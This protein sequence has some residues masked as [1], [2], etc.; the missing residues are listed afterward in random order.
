M[1]LS[2]CV[3]DFS[4][5]VP[6]AD[7]A[8]TVSG[9]TPTVTF[10]VPETIYLNPSDT[11]E[12]QY[13]VN[14]KS[15][16]TLVAS[17]NDTSGIIYFNCSSATAVTGLTCN[18][19]T[20]SL[21]ATSSTSGSLSTTINSGS[22]SSD[23]ASGSIGQLEWAVFFTVGG[24]T[25]TAVAYTTVYSPYTKP[26]GAAVYNKNTAGNT[27]FCSIISWWQGVHGFTSRG[28]YTE[29]SINRLDSS[30]GTYSGKTDSTW[31][32]NPMVQG[33]DTSSGS[34]KNPTQWLN[35]D[36]S[37][38]IYF[39]YFSTGNGGN[40]LSV[41]STGYTATLTMDISR[42]NNINQVPN[43]KA[44]FM[45]A[46]N[47]G[48]SG[49]MNYWSVAEYTG[50]NYTGR[51]TS[52]DNK[53]ELMCDT[54]DAYKFDSSTSVITSDGNN[55]S[56][57]FGVKYNDIFSKSITGSTFFVFKSFCQLKG[58][59]KNSAYNY[60]YVDSATYCP[61]SITAVNKGDLRT[62]VTNCVNSY[63]NGNYTSA[64]WVNF[65]SALKAAALVLGNPTASESDIS[66]ANTN[67]TT[68]KNN[69]SAL[70]TG[71]V[72]VKHVGS[73]GKDFGVETGTTYNYGQNI[74]A[75]A[76]TV[77]GYTYTSTACTVN[78]FNLNDFYNTPRTTSA[79]SNATATLSNGVLSVTGTG[80]DNYTG[81]PYWDDAHNEFD[82]YY[83]P[84]TPGAKYVLS[85]T[86]TGN[87]AQAYVFGV[88]VFG[89]SSDAISCASNYNNG[90]QTIEYTVPANV[91]YVTFRFGN[92]S[93]CTT[94]FENIKF[95]KSG[96]T[97]TFV[98]NVC[99]GAVEFTLTYT[100]ITY[101]VEYN[102]NGPT[103]GSTASST[104]TYDAAKNLTANGYSRTGYIYGGWSET[105]GGAKKYDNGQSVI[106]LTATNNATVNLYAVWTPIAY[107]VAY[108]GNG[109]TDGTTAS[110]S[111]TYDTAKNL[112]T[113][114]F[115]REFVVTYNVA[116]N[117]GTCATASDTATATFNG[118]TDS[119]GGDYND[120][121][122][123]INLT[124]DNGA[125]V[126]MYAKWTDGSVNLP[127]STKDPDENYHYTLA[128]W[129]TSATG[130]TKIGDAEASYTPSADT[131]LYAQYSSE[132]HV[133][134][135]EV[136]QAATCTTPGVTKYTCGCGYSYTDST[137][138][139]VKAHTPVTI[140]AV[141]A[142]CTT[143]GN[144][145]YYQCSECKQYFSNSSCTISTTPEAQVTPVLG[146]TMETIAAVTATCK[147]TGNNLYYHCTRCDKYY[148]DDQGNTATTSDAE[149]TA[150]DADN[151]VGGT[152]LR[153]RVA[154]TCSA[155]GYTGDTY[156]LGCG[157]LL[158]TGN[159]T[160]QLT[161]SFDDWM[162]TVDATCIAKGE[163][164][165]SCTRTGCGYTETK[166]IAIDPD[167]HENIV[168]DAAVAATCTTTGLTAGKHC[169]ACGVVTVAQTVTE[170][171]GHDYKEEN[172]SYND[173]ATCT[174]DG[175]ETCK[176]SRCDETDTRTK[177]G[178]SLGHD[179]KNYTAKAPTCTEVGW[180]A[181][182]ACTRCD[183]TT[184]NEIAKLG[185]NLVH[186]EAQK[187]SCTND[188][189]EAYDTCTRCDY[190]TQVVEP[191][192]GHDW[193]TATCTEAAVCTRCGTSSGT[194]IGHDFTEQ[195]IDA[196]HLKSEATCTA[197]AVYYYDC[198]RC[199]EIST[200]K[201]FEY[202][203]VLGHKFDDS[204][205][206]NVTVVAAQCET[207]GSKTVKCSRCDETQVTVL[208]ATGHTE[209]EIPAVPATC[210]DSG[211]TA[212]VKC[213]VCQK[214]LTAQTTVKAL[215][216]DFDES[217]EANVTV[218]PAQCTVDGSKTVKCSRC[219]A[220][221]ETVI[222]APGH[223]E[224]IIPAVPATCT[225]DGS[226]AGSKC[227]VCGEIIEATTV[228]KAFGHTPAATATQENGV[229]ATCSKEGSC[230]EV[231]YCTTCKEELS[232][233]HVVLE[234]TAHN[235]VKIREISPTC[236]ETGLTEGSE[237]SVCGEIIKAQEV[238]EALGHIYR[239]RI[240]VPV[241][242]Q[243]AGTTVY[244]CRRC[245][246]SYT[247]TV[248]K[249]DHNPGEAAKENVVAATCTT[250]GSYNNVVRCTMCNE[251]LSSE[252]VETDYA[253][254]T[255]EIIPAVEATCRSTGLTEGKKCKRCGK[256]LVEQQIVEMTEHNP[257]ALED[258]QP[259][260]TQEGYT[261]KVV[262]SFCGMILVEPA[263]TPATGHTWGEWTT[264]VEAT[265]EAD[266]YKERACTV[267]GA[268]EKMVIS[269][270]EKRLIKFYVFEGM[271]YII[272]GKK[273]SNTTT[274]YSNLG[275]EV[276]FKVG[277][278]S[279][280][281]FA[282][283][284]ICADGV[285][286]TKGDD[287]YYTIPGGVNNV[288]VTATAIVEVPD[289]EST[290]ESGSGS[291]TGTKR[292]SFWEWLLSIF[293]KF[294]AL[295]T[296]GK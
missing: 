84:V 187:V 141:A 134:S 97:A 215:G 62:N 228:I 202:G 113:N 72:T 55:S 190:T 267:C 231:I 195:V 184:Y 30:S 179:L 208:K 136:T 281:L 126:N 199:S 45:V 118:W 5:L 177:S 109:A 50:T 163:Q 70:K 273:Y 129:Y 180:D 24:E 251:I 200:D 293:R 261:G 217:I 196:A 96:S 47:E 213:S 224:V 41:M 245:G 229:S 272:D 295:F 239:E 221:N 120:G 220:T 241:S 151:H 112:T 192:L 206:A 183:Y 71:S 219:D 13:Y 21:G 100:P 40:W 14:T 158:S 164:T 286:L 29:A 28:S 246:D 35:S 262:C 56:A 243:E 257:V 104:H 110:S 125:T 240:T 230:D 132:G 207:D 189:W 128:G 75:S 1:C 77:T 81:M 10:Y 216:H 218:V 139:L 154:A 166:E 244:T 115:K 282:G 43:L 58:T 25:R 86:A 265:Y 249:L 203:D 274:G 48:N 269:I 3:L 18:G 39:A 54:D 146:H 211:L 105:A 150:I 49:D 15:D 38:Q 78:Y 16:G 278:S 258:T 234:K 76:K 133:Y 173:D 64:T 209:V 98:T 227:S 188:G 270:G 59:R 191:A 148:K 92:S 12:F 280:N 90:A 296:G 288:I 91:A 143:T 67:L 279:G 289:K 73:N 124:A 169:S 123:V 46:D 178:T 152:E 8:V 19:A 198:S 238:I 236:T 7:A 226:T 162:T 87:T 22:L 194:V 255:E 223:T 170:A 135:S 210:T 95:I 156:C 80:N 182:E 93:A 142:T 130:G 291:S 106:N 127:A 83:I 247:E 147:S 277:T 204:I 145:E 36:S 275:D 201:T 250:K 122:S 23:L 65:Q 176:C 271:Y 181:Y 144:N 254:H 117:G 89:H 174:A 42:Y 284:T 171:L 155:P 283:Y 268:T 85:Y 31:Y 153:N 74:S 222:T 61:I 2:V 175:T 37:G 17:A 111:H 266:G 44:G 68:A 263:V 276:K 165:R 102:G 11:S 159:E 119:V 79:C 248:E 193:G 27:A 242:C 116:T 121:D 140:A 235:A 99:A 149:V 214:V 292:M 232:R 66:T 60:P 137:I 101:T 20:V 103:K 287:G 285:E 131:T 167:N 32:L 33:I 185:H 294:A 108:N 51:Y 63:L 186:H 114:G 9:S 168:D 52:D 197:K 161:H 88:D 107:T 253:A 157:A 290:D 225:T 264:V 34:N 26:V 4:G 138:P 259:T 252:H 233:T 94:T 82:N 237:C 260:C 172:Y 6:Y 205:T 160:N 57:S 69:L 53:H 256:I 212:G